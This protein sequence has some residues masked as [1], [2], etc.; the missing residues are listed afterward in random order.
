MSSRA[1]AFL[2]GRQSNHWPGNF[3]SEHEL[4]IGEQ[5]VTD[6]T[7]NSDILHYKFQ[8]TIFVRSSPGTLDTKHSIGKIKLVRT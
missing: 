8:P 5:R 1:H 2:S 6:I 3:P 4:Q 7:G